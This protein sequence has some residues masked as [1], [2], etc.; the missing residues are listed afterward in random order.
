M[1]AQGLCC[2]VVGVILKSRGGKLK[3]QTE[4]KKALT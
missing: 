1:V 4:S 2:V 3:M